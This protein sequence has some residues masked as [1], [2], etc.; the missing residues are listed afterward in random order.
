MPRLS[1][2]ATRWLSAQWKFETFEATFLVFCCSTEINLRV[3][4][5]LRSLSISVTI[6][7]PQLR[8]FYLRNVSKKR[9]SGKFPIRCKYLHAIN[10]E[11]AIDRKM[12]HKYII[13]FS[14]GIHVP[15]RE[16]HW[17][18]IPTVN[19]LTFPSTILCLTHSFSGDVSTETESMQRCLQKF[20]A[21]NQSSSLPAFG[22]TNLR[23]FL[24]RNHSH[25]NL[26]SPDLS[27]RTSILCRR[28]FGRGWLAER[29]RRALVAPESFRLET[30]PSSAPQ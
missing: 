19:E 12:W 17:E 2:Q 28:G 22:N 25:S 11:S 7:S 16:E 1:Q 23:I 4:I 26:E 6:I 15:T 5:L 21:P 9:N 30:V 18:G 20:L 3:N 10:S 8:R 24:A 13:D 29:T 27:T 14:F